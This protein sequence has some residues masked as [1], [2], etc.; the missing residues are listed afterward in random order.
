MS[1]N[2]NALITLKNLKIYLVIDKDTYN[3]ILEKLINAV[4]QDLE[5]RLGWSL[6]YTSYSSAAYDGAGEQ[7]LFLPGRPIWAVSAL[8]EGDE[9]LTEDT[10]FVIKDAGSHLSYLRKII[11]GLTSENTLVWVK[12][13]NNIVISYT[14]GWWVEEDPAEG[15]GATEMPSDIQMAVAMQVGVMWKRFKAEDWDITGQAFGDGSISKNIVEFH[16]LYKEVIKHYRRP[17]L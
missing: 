5:N 8:T 15:D 16:P 12:G 10:D 13:V 17:I 1:L 11:S 9:T 14:G 4:S 3:P 2:D 6:V 7:M